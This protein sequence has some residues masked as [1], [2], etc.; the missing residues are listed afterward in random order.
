MKLIGKQTSSPIIESEAQEKMFDIFISL[1]VLIG[2]IAVLLGIH[3]LDS[4]IGLIIAIFIIKGGYEIFLMST[5]TLLDAVIDFDN[6][7]ELYNLIENTP[8]V[9]EIETMEIRSYGRYIFL[10]LEIC[11]RKD[12]PLSQIAAL[13]NKLRNDIKKNFPI[14]FKILINLLS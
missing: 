12:F 1:S 7:T 5:K 9:K 6:R 4:I 14:I 3:I 2:F 8:K 10:E 11:L 13:K